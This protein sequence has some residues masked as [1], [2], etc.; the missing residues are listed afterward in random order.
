MKSFIEE[1]LQNPSQAIANAQKSSSS[2][3]WADN[4]DDETIYS[5]IASPEFAL[6]QA[7]VNN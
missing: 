2:S 1:Y 5:Q 6:Y 7:I 4:I 3:T